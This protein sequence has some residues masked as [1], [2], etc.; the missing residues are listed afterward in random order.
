M[1]RACLWNLQ[2][3]IKKLAQRVCQFVEI[4]L[5]VVSMDL[6]KKAEV[7]DFPNYFTISFDDSLFDI[8]CDVSDVMVT[9]DI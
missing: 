7:G 1:S 8:S 3:V 5:V 4:A 2:K 6:R 9:N